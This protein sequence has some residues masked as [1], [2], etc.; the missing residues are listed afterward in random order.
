MQTKQLGNSELQ[1]TPIGFGAFIIGGNPR[2]RC[3]AFAWDKKMLLFCR[4]AIAN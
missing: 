4:C 1:I 2:P 3:L